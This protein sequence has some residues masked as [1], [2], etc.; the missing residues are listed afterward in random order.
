MSSLSNK[1]KQIMKRVLSLV[2]AVILIFSCLVISV[3]AEDTEIVLGDMDGDGVVKI[4]DAR[5]ILQMA[6]AIIEPDVEKADMNL[7]G[8]VSL[9]DARA[10]LAISIDLIELPEKTGDNLISDDPNNE[11]IKLI[12]TKYKIDPQ[13]LVAIYAVPDKGNNFVLEFEKT[14]NGYSR[15]PDDLKKL[16][17]IDLERNI[18]I[19]TKTGIG[20]V[21]CSASESIFMFSLVKKVIMPEYPDYFDLD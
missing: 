9:E 6:A 19:A 11:F 15:S 2:F 8:V 18:N 3:Y 20:C 13:A 7:D 10:A 16:Y 4:V 14:K 17:Q 1:K 12:S 21:G 5:I